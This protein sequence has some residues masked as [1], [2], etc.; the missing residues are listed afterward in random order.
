MPPAG[1]CVPPAS[2]TATGGQ[3]PT[4]DRISPP[5]SVRGTHRVPRCTPG[6]QSRTASECPDPEQRSDAAATTAHEWARPSDAYAR[7]VSDRPTA[8]AR[9]PMS[10][11]RRAPRGHGRLCP[12]PDARTSLIPAPSPSPAQAHP[13]DH[14]AVHRR[15]S[16]TAL[17][18]ERRPATKRDGLVRSTRDTQ[19]T[20]GVTTVTGVISTARRVREWLI[21]RA[22]GRGG[23]PAARD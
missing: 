13:V 6:R 2:G 20:S 19:N 12:C 7:A 4:P 3:P 5:D 9:R 1:P 22:G 17:S 10:V 14:H 23:K 15:P 16:P 11:R 8:P 18:A 21:R